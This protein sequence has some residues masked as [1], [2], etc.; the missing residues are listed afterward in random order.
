MLV[1][2]STGF[3]HGLKEI[4]ESQEVKDILS[5]TIV[6]KETEIFEQFMYIASH[7]EDKACYGYDAVK[8]AID[9]KAVKDLLISDSLYWSVDPVK[10]NKYVSIVARAKA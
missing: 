10:R 7:E 8:M 3:K 6:G 1:H 9:Q 2:I 4:L 5:E